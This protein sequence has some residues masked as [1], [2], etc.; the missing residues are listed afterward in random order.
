MLAPDDR[1]MLLEL[2]E[3]PEGLELD[4][5]VGVT[6]TLNLEALLSI[7]TAF[8]V[9]G[10]LGEEEVHADLAPI[11]LLD[12]LRTHARRITVCCDS[13]GVTLPTNAA[14]GV[15]SFLE[16]C[17]VP[18]RAP[19]GGAFHPKAWVVRYSATGAEATH[20]LIISSRNLTF[21]RSWDT[22]V[23]LE[24]TPDGVAL[25]AVA[26]LL[27]ALAGD[28]LPVGELAV[29]NQTRLEELA[30]SVRSARFALPAGFDDMSLHVL[31]L[32]DK[33]RSRSPLPSAARRAL[34]VSPFLSYAAID[35]VPVAWDALTVVSRR[36][37]LDA[38]LGSHPREHVDG[39]V[40]EI[41]TSAIDESGTTEDSLT[42]LHAK[43]WV[44]DEAARRSQ[45]FVGSANATTAAFTSNVEVLLELSGP[46]S[47]VGVE[48]WINGDESMRE[49][50]V[51]H[52]WRDPEPSET[53]NRRLLTEFRR[54][55][56]R[57]PILA[58]IS[59]AADSR[60][61]IRFTAVG[62][63]ARP[64]GVR[65]SVR[66][67]AL[68]TWTVLSGGID[69]SFTLDAAALSAFLG[70]RLELSEEHCEFVLVA[71]VTGMPA[72]RDAKVLAALLANPERL[73]RY[74]L[75]LL[76]DPLDDRFDGNAQQ[77]IEKAR[78]VTHD[79]LSA[80]PLLEVMARALVRQPKRLA[81]IDRLIQELDEGTDII[82]TDLK[83]LW[84][85]VRTVA[86]IRGPK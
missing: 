82:D 25:P 8:A 85:A 20:R 5:A 22:A 29:A 32:S 43:L 13:S 26:T 19:R 74:L 69:A 33:Q 53:D 4:S 1:S 14:S 6:Y 9:A 70:I 71:T 45:V 49:L 44:F 57:L 23:S 27:S 86:G 54:S 11:E 48:R 2:L 15:F 83:A 68:K 21:D 3:P 66:P 77:A 79:T 62:A 40:F 80:V 12:A 17:I 51:P 73:V 56:S 7:P 39:N 47:R 31:G 35:Q 46:T 50:L 60:Y 67:L 55:L 75:M 34:V 41:T 16:S 72:N 63:G 30:T 28:A 18:V 84:T 38:E 37:Q 78:H 10:A 24:Q 65:V 76:A 61:T 36:D 81:E 64:D 52:L 42:G 58:D 59:E